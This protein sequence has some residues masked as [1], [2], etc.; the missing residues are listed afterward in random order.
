MNN[1]TFDLRLNTESHI[2]VHKF[3]AGAVV[4]TMVAALVLQALLPVYFPKAAILDLP[5]LLTTYFGLSRRNP[6]TGLLLGMVIGLLQ[7]SLSKS[8]LGLYGIAKTL[9][10]FIASS[11]GGRLDTEHPASRFA[12]V[13]VFFGVHQGVIVLIK[14][15]LLAQPEIWFTMRLGLAAVVNGVVAVGLFF[16]LDRLRKPS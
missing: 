6:S 9:I 4:A 5:L 15:L 10:G 16:L 13:I 12:L 14:R 7:D 2:E 8:P 11:I 3:R 1:D